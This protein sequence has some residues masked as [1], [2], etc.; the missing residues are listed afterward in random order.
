[1]L[2]YFHWHGLLRR[3]E[4]VPLL[5]SWLSYDLLWRWQFRLLPRRLAIRVLSDWLHLL[6]RRLWNSPLLSAWHHLLRHG[7]LLTLCREEG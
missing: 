7:L 6:P 4:W 3:R 2:Q 1:V 5:P